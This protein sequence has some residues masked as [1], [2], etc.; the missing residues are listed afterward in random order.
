M[1]T[2]VGDGSHD[3]SIEQWTAQFPGL[4]VK[5]SGVTRLG[6]EA[7]QA[8]YDQIPLAAAVIFIVLILQSGSWRS[9]LVGLSIIPLGLTGS[10]LVLS[11]CGMPLS[12]MT[13]LGIT[14]MSG[15]SL[16]IAIVLTAA[17][18]QELADGGDVIGAIS[19][20]AASRL[21]PILLTTLCAFAGAVPLA[22]SGDGLWLPVALA[23]IGGLSLATIGGL[24][25]IPLLSWLFA[26]SARSSRPEHP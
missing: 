4:V 18:R 12:F 17:I 11:L 23:L 1:I 13:I 19:R 25:L 5:D 10:A 22:F 16:N 24:L 6:A 26:R 20:A 3:V 2:L 9:L 8:F 15:L 7:S 14:A 21:E